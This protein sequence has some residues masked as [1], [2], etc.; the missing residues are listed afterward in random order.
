MQ[1]RLLLGL[2]LVLVFVCHRV[3]AS[4]S[5]ADQ[6]KQEAAE[7]YSRRIKPMFRERCYSCHGARKQ[8]ANLRLD[9]AEAIR[10]GGDSGPAID[11]EHPEKSL[12]IQKVT[13]TEIAERMP[14]EFEGEPLSGEQVDALVRWIGAEAPALADD[15]PEK[16]PKQHWAFQQVVR[17]AVPSVSSPHGLR[18]PIDHFLEQQRQTVG[19]SASPA[20]PPA[21]LLRRVY[22]DLIGIPPTLEEIEAFEN[23]SSD[24]AYEKIVERLL[25]DPRHG[26]RWGRH[27]M[28]IWRYSD[29]WGLG[30]QLRNSNPHIWHWRDWIIESLNADMPY[31]RMVQL[32]LAADELEPSDL[33]SLRAS[34]YLVRNYFLFNRHQ[35][36]EETVEHVSKGFLGLTMNCSK[37]HDHKFDPIQ[38][39]DFYRLRAFFEPYHVRVDAVPGEADLTRD[40]IARAFDGMPETPTYRFV[41][42]NE[43]APDKSVTITPGVPE[44]LDFRPI[45][46]TPV[47]LPVDAWQP[48][49]RAFVAE[50]QLR[51]AREKLDAARATLEQIKQD[52]NALP[53]EIRVKECAESL[54]ATELKLLDCG[55]AALT[56]ASKA[57]VV[58]AK[59]CVEVAR[60]E[61]AV[62]EIDLR[63]RKA[64]ADKREP[65]EKEKVAAAATLEKARSRQN[66]P[67]SAEESVSVLVGAKWVPTRFLNSTADDPAV[68]FVPTSTGRRAELARW[69]TDPRHPL[70]A[71]VAVNHV[72]ARHM[73]TPLVATVFDFGLNGH[74]PTHPELLDWLAAEFVASG[75]SMKHLH[76]LMVTSS[77]Y[78]MSS[79]I[80]GQEESHRVDSENRSWWRRTPMRLDSQVVRDSLLS[81]AGTL[82]TVMGGPP[83]AP[84][85][86]ELSRRRSL[87]FFH[88]NNDRNRFLTLFDEAAVK[89]CYRRE[90]S[91]VPQQA[92]ALSNSKLVQQVTPAIVERIEQG[93][94]DPKDDAEFIQDAFATVLA[95]RADETEMA[96]CRD[97]LSSWRSLGTNDAL[98]SPR[99]MLI[100]SLINHNDFVTVR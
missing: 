16:D 37:C 96:A 56:S 12:L 45:E 61:H 32:M 98:A 48:E 17:P 70:T 11:M 40:G 21:T 50:A 97:A 43:N 20:A 63:L 26:E 99:S 33:G 49:R 38:Q 54:A 58:A 88:S 79:S 51:V 68:P 25:Q 81:L 47:P 65:I 73:G 14:P 53:V 66:E 7:E 46:I 8:E 22:L 2:L 91:I 39:V 85:D 31:D 59:R 76:R 42:G 18:N 69:L 75:W 89:E 52:P 83:V 78:R 60:A 29:W 100:W 36:L 64:E 95:G 35:W 55:V 1:R 71:R 3:E 13:T 5:A 82:E 84:K 10:T 41:R 94:V 9:T 93:M 24:V 74:S 34:G 67:V 6:R 90:E 87:Y 28:D 30:D 62:A 15:V 23:D 27:W 72:W 19:V 44:I 4:S 57:E 80:R 86:Q 77:A 92:L